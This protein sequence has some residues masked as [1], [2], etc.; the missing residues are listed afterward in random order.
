MT[1]NNSLV[2]VE[3]FSV[4]V[5]PLLAGLDGNLQLVAL[6]PLAMYELDE[7]G[8]TYKIPEDYLVWEETD[9]YTSSFENWLNL[10]ESTTARLYPEVS[11]FYIPMS[12][13]CVAVLKGMVDSFVRKAVQF[14]RILKEENPS[15]IY[16]FANRNKSGQPN[17]EL[18]FFQRSIFYRIAES[19]EAT[20]IHV[21]DVGIKKV[22]S[23][24]DIGFIRNVYDWFRYCRFIWFGKPSGWTYLF[25]ST[26]ATLRDMKF[27][28]RKCKVV[29]IVDVIVNRTGSFHWDVDSLCSN[30]S[31][32]C[33]VD[34]EL[35]QVVVGPQLD[36]YL[37][38]VVPK[39]VEHSKFYFEYLKKFPRYKTAVIFTR[40]NRLYQYGLL[41]AAK[42]L[43]IPTYYVKHGWE[44]YNSWITDWRRLKVYD[45]F[46]A[47]RE[48]ER[49]FFRKHAAENG[50]KCE[51]L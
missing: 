41:I 48:G 29:P 23:W 11:S 21:P 14:E 39:I 4:E 3:D 31:D 7:L 17:D 28:F 34:L 49:K 6:S 5:E 38:C 33:G 13:Y 32:F 51:V 47:S 37:K 26:M 50:F 15:K 30:L 43:G 20:L 44:G 8:L 16:Y 1:T 2:F 18:L 27:Q 12:T 36:H 45:H 40:R 46:V 10:V 22:T 9:K 19:I 25:A 24:R 35:V 42:Q